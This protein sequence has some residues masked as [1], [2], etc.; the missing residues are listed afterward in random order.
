M[1]HF[2]FSISL[3]I[4]Q[5]DKMKIQ[6]KTEPVFTLHSVC[7]HE[8]SVR[9]WFITLF[10]QPIKCDV[11]SLL[12]WSY[13]IERISA[14]EN[15]V[16]AIA[17]RKRVRVSNDR[18]SHLQNLNKYPPEFDRSQCLNFEVHFW[19][20]RINF[21]CVFLRMNMLFYWATVLSNSSSSINQMGWKNNG[22][23]CCLNGRFF[24]CFFLVATQPNAM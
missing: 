21:R 24:F 16:N 12:K 20:I 10:L 9:I 17:G 1:Y 2:F 7:A 6:T 23:F 14:W 18:L 15:I 19:W 8:N 22:L 13:G 5:H 3:E 4:S 11:R